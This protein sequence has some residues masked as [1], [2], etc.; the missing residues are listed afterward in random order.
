MY[1]YANRVSILC[2]SVN[3]LCSDFFDRF[4]LGIRLLRVRGERCG[5]GVPQKWFRR[6]DIFTLILLYF[7]VA[8]R[9][10]LMRTCPRAS[11]KMCEFE[12]RGCSPAKLECDG[13]IAVD[14][15]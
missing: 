11:T 15:T 8:V 14:R 4:C 13:F 7:R 9:P 6:D 3:R 5:V 1:I 10:F 2:T 12:I